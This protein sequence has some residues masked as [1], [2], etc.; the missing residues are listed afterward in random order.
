MQRIG[1]ILLLF[2][3]ASMPAFAQ[4]PNPKDYKGMLPGIPAPP[5]GITQQAGRATHYVD[6]TNAA[7]T[8]SGNPNGTAER[9]RRTIPG[10]VG[11]GS[12]VEVRGGPYDLGNGVWSA[13]GTASAPVFIK[14]I[15]DPVMHGERIAFAGA[16]LIVEGIVFDGVPI[17]MS[18]TMS[19]LALR[20]STVR[21]WSPSG[22]SAAVVPAGSNLVFFAN[23]I[24]N[25]GDPTQDSE[26][27]VHG[28]KAERGAEKIWI[29][30]NNIHH[31]GGDGIQLGN[32]T[33]LEPWPNQIYIGQNGIHQDRENAV[34]IKKARDVVVSGNLMFGYEARSSS[35]GE[36][37]VT[38]DG[39]Q[40]I[41]IVDNAVGGSR[42]G[43]VCSG[44]DVYGVIGNVI[45][46]VQ[47]SPGDTKY[48]PGSLF[49]TAG[50]L[51]YNTTNSVH[52]N[53][54]IWS[55]DAG[56]SYAGGN[57]PT[58][59][60]NNLIGG[61]TQR[62]HHIAIGSSQ[63]A[64]ASVVSGNLVDGEP[65]VRR[66]GSPRGCEGSEC[67][68]VAAK[69]VDPPRDM[70]PQRGS[71]VID[72]GTLPSIFAAFQQRYGLSIAVDLFGTPRPQGPSFDVGAAEFPAGSPPAPKNLRIVPRH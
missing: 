55:S 66:G 5:F 20:F 58:E 50:I 26:R 51:T 17:V 10:S 56:I 72:A 18:P 12:V 62:S 47:H 4:R 1:G 3:M 71:P 25:N 13:E 9:P 39:A 29:L 44:A 32:A 64:E 35:A 22:H 38:H 14:G 8:D 67:R 65:R 27:D 53:N 45:G 46:N 40:R 23:E 21:N 41:W 57:A 70:R 34:D 11:A 33:S 69:L 30:L 7:A 16:Y 31:N 59:I 15:G 52:V 63:A 42:Q 6:N 19:F 24:H 49:R 28:I 54:T 61:L 36:V 2:T 48:D 60:V 68:S 37:V 43:I